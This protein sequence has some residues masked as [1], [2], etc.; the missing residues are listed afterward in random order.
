MVSHVLDS[1]TT[2]MH[3]TMVAEGAFCLGGWLVAI[4]LVTSAGCLGLCSCIV[5]DNY[6]HT[7]NSIADCTEDWTIP[8]M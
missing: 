4:K 3:A 1:E 2:S 5:R 8:Q 7:S 6:S